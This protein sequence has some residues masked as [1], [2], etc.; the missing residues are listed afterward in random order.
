ML[1]VLQLGQ[2]N[3]VGLGL[4]GMLSSAISSR[5]F[6][7]N[8]ENT[9]V[10]RK[11]GTAFIKPVLGSKPL[12]ATDAYQNA[13]VWFCSKLSKLTGQDVNFMLVAK[14]ATGIEA[15]DDRTSSPFLFNE[16]CANWKSSG[17]GPAD[18][19][20][21]SGHENNRG[22]SFAA[23]AEKQDHVIARLIEECVISSSTVIV[24][25]GLAEGQADHKALNDN[26]LKPYCALRGY[27]YARS[28]GLAQQPLP[29]LSH[30]V[31]QSYV[32]M[33]MDRIFE[34]L[35]PCSFVQAKLA[36]GLLQYG[37]TSSGEFWERSDGFK[38]VRWMPILERAY[39]HSLYRLWTFPI[40]FVSAPYIYHTVS[41]MQS[42]EMSVSKIG[43]SFFMV[44]GF[45]NSWA[46]LRLQS[47]NLYTNGGEKI[48]LVLEASGY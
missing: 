41:S 15:Y 21:H 20:I 1:S 18:F 24:I 44:D 6:A 46:Q 22:D 14:G 26:V 45:N 30:F 47:D 4:G 34:A 23:Y 43:G 11:A 12:N 7:W 33:G 35:P 29:D 17:M 37:V 10:A 31:G 3:A 39:T 32:E 19:L 9:S 8:N 13:G 42:R 16:T 38:T 36:E 5:V 25:T 48:G 2:S 40:R 28:D 27:C